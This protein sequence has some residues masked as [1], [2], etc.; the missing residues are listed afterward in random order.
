MFFFCIKIFC[1]LFLSCYPHTVHKAKKLVM[2]KIIWPAHSLILL[3]TTIVKKHISRKQYRQSDYIQDSILSELIIRA[4]T[5]NL[6]A[7]KMFLEIVQEPQTI[8]AMPDANSTV[9]QQ[10]IKVSYKAKQ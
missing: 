9:T 7:I 2:E 6:K 1:F 10:E 3:N 8:I 4:Q 5:G